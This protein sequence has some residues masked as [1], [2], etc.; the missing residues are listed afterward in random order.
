MIDAWVWVSVHTAS[1]QTYNFNSYFSIELNFNFEIPFCWVVEM[2]SLWSYTSV[3][4]VLILRFMGL[5]KCQGIVG[6]KIEGEFGI[7]CHPLVLTSSRTVFHLI[8]SCLSAQNTSEFLF[9]LT[10]R[11]FQVFSMNLSN[12]IFRAMQSRRCKAHLFS[13]QSSGG[14]FLGQELLQP[15]NHICGFL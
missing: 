5:I 3:L 10:I 13:S 14:N 6:M 11:F 8:F 15:R 4:P 1:L 7:G 12:T 9:F 2:Q